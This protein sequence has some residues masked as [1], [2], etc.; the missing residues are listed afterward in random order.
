MRNLCTEK[1]LNTLR[2]S[3]E[4]VI[5][6]SM[7]KKRSRWLSTSRGHSPSKLLS[8]SVAIQ[9]REWRTSSSSEWGSSR[10]KAGIKTYQ[11]P[12]NGPNRDYTS[13]ES[14]NDDDLRSKL[15]FTIVMFCPKGLQKI[16]K[17][18]KFLFVALCV[19]NLYKWL[20]LCLCQH[21]T[22]SLCFNSV[23]SVWSWPVCMVACQ[24]AAKPP[25]AKSQ[26]PPK[27][28]NP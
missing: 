4:N 27:G 7:Q 25:K 1:K 15:C 23:A 28:L 18:L 22:F 5:W 2:V 13:W 9:W 16:N 6:C 19:N 21:H 17:K 11:G 20:Y 8:A 12:Q 10:T 3:A 24:A 26:C 14:W